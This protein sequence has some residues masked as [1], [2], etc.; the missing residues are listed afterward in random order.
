MQARPG[1]RVIFRTASMTSTAFCQDGI[2]GMIIDEGDG[3]P[4]DA[5]FFERGESV[6][7]V[8]I[9]SPVYG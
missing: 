4:I 2:D 7:P 6:D 3:D 8:E 1:A 5:Y 9:V